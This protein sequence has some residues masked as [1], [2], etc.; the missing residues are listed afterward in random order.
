MEPGEERLPGQ[1]VGAMRLFKA[2]GSAGGPGPTAVQHYAGECRAGGAVVSIIDHLYTN[3]ESRITSP[4]V[5]HVGDSDHLGLV[6]KKMSNIAAEKPSTFKIRNHEK[7]N[8]LVTSLYLN[9]VRELITNCNSLED[10][11]ETF[12][13]EVVYYSNIHIP[14]TTIKSN[15]KTKQFLKYTTKDLLKEKEKAYKLFKNT[16]S[17]DDLR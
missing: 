6:I 12:R 5:L 11:A 10:A 4:Q 14:I 2:D 17:K 16:R 8:D 1:G 13:R 15:K 9:N 3:C 7:I